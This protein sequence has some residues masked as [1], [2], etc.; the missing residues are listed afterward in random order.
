MISAC[1]KKRVES[2]TT[3]VKAHA[4][5]IVRDQQN[6]IALA[7]ALQT[8]RNL[9]PR[10]VRKCVHDRIEN[11]IGQHLS[12]WTRVAVHYQARLTRNTE[13]KIVLAHTRPQTRQDLLDE[14]T[15]IEGAL[16]QIMAI[17]RHLLK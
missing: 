17:N 12:E 10:P 7:G 9:A 1:R 14:F 2:L 16:I 6:H 3:H 8:D 13:C 15:G 11:Q 4:A 5:T